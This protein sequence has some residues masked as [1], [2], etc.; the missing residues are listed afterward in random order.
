ML[1]GVPEANTRWI[2]LVRI[3]IASSPSFDGAF[4]DRPFCSIEHPQFKW[5]IRA[6]RTVFGDVVAPGS[7]DCS[8]ATIGH[9][10]RQLNAQLRAKRETLGA[11]TSRRL[12]QRR[13]RGASV[14]SPSAPNCRTRAMAKLESLHFRRANTSDVDQ[15]ADAHRDSIIHL[16]SPY[17]APAI[18]NAWAGA[19]NPGI[20]VNA[21]D[22]GEVFFVATGRVAGKSMVLGFSSDYAISGT[23]HGTSAYVRPIA[24]RRG[25]GSR[26]LGLAESFARSG[27]ATPI[28]IDASLGAVD[29]YKHHGFV[30][31]TRGSLTL[32]SSVRMP[33]VNMRKELR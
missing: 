14:S 21:M 22:E 4:Q 17:Y 32:A 25:V 1:G 5:S 7:R 23:T 20:Y 13:D 30:E 15:M 16:G 24:A 26:L 27:G 33:C 3:S 28:Q 6:C 10:S 9:K 29:F 12:I 8:R 2:A 19:V 31:T 11:A 18:V